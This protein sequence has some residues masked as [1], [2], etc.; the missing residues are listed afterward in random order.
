MNLLFLSLIVL[1]SFACLGALFLRLQKDLN[2]CVAKVNPRA[3][4]KFQD[5]R[6]SEFYNA[7]ADRQPK[8]TRTVLLHEAA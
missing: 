7:F 5:D 4:D 1:A 2:G 6:A 8:R 3:R